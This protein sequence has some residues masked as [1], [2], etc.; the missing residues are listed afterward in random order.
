MKLT[1]ILLFTTVWLIA[2]QAE[3]QTVWRNNDEE[4]ARNPEQESGTS[5][6]RRLLGRG[7]DTLDRGRFRGMGDEMN[8]DVADYP[9]YYKAP[10]DYAWSSPSWLI[11]VLVVLLSLNLVVQCA[12]LWKRNHAAK[13]QPAQF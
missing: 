4:M 7:R 1:A 2:A 5:A 9:S 3:A 12:V 11:I 6:A 13:W 8:E 10:T